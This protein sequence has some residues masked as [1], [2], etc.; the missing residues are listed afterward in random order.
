MEGLGLV[1]LRLVV[2]GA[3]AA[4]PCALLELQDHERPVGDIEF[5]PDPV[6]AGL[7]KTKTRVV[8]GVSEN[9]DE[10][11]RAVAEFLDP[12]LDEPRADPCPLCPTIAPQH[13][14]AAV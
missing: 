5:A 14:A 7:H 12:V 3:P 10:T 9:D 6:A 2:D 11:V 8:G 1:E 4:L 13:V